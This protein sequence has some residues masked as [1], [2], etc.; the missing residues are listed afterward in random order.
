MD[1]VQGLDP[2]KLVLAD[3]VLIPNL[4]TDVDHLIVQFAGV[5]LLAQPICIPTLQSSY[6]LIWNLRA[7]KHGQCSGIA[8]STWLNS[9]SSEYRRA[10]PI[11]YASSPVC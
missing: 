5:I 6:L 11:P 3:T 9:S 7:R 4:I 1:F 2:S 10:K 8:N